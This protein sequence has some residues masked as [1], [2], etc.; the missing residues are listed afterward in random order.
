[1]YLFGSV[2]EILKQICYFTNKDLINEIN[3]FVYFPSKF[4]LGMFK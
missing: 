1:M 3:Y 2:D 4:V